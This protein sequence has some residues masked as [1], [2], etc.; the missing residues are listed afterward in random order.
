MYHEIEEKQLKTKIYTHVNIDAWIGKHAGMGQLLRDI[1]EEFTPSLVPLD[2]I[3]G[4]SF[5]VVAADHGDSLT[6]YNRRWDADVNT[7]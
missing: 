1:A 7:P 3:Q 6:R 5:Q 2:R 4:I